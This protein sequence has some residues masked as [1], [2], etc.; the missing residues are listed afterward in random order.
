[1]ANQ[2]KPYNIN[3]A[4]GRRKLREQ[5]AINYENASPEEK[6]E[7]DNIGCTI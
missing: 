6:A 7:R 4:Y 5:A 1:M 3:S 2:R